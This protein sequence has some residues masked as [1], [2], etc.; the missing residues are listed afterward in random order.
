M[1]NNTKNYP[2]AKKKLTGIFS[3]LE[4]QFLAK[5]FSEICTPHEIDVAQLYIEHVKKFYQKHLAIYEPILNIDALLTKLERLDA[6]DRAF[7]FNE[8]QRIYN[9]NGAN[10]DDLIITK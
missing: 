8:L 6:Y 1:I 5:A 2:D 7:V 4:A 10:I 3:L 9:G